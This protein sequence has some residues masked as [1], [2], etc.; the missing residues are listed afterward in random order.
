MRLR[1]I[2]FALACVWAMNVSAQ[3]IT[4]YAN[5]VELKSFVTNFGEVQRGPLRFVKAEITLQIAPN[6]SRH[7]VDAHMAHI[8]NDLN[9]LLNE[10]MEEDLA[11]V[12]AQ[13]V[14]AQKALRVVQDILIAETG[15]AQVDDL[16]FTSLVIQ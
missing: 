14:L 5:Y 15:S 2:V 4:E 13:A 1:S 10:Q 9:F 7:D 16:F 12:E 6:G 3:S 8:R 11:S